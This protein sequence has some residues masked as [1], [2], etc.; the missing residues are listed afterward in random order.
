M[1]TPKRENLSFSSPVAIMS[2]SEDDVCV[3]EEEV[4]EDMDVLHEVDDKNSKTEECKILSTSDV[5]SVMTD[6]IKTVEAVTQIPPTTI[7]ILLNRFR[8]DKEKMMDKLYLGENIFELA[9][10]LSPFKVESP[11]VKSKSTH[12]EICFMELEENAFGLNCQHYYCME[13]WAEYLKLKVIDGKPINI[14][15]GPLTL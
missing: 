1:F 11:K 12:C 15:K 14:A 6:C 8:W 5:I 4:D 7:R 13:C 2:S 10:I 3:Y 9:G